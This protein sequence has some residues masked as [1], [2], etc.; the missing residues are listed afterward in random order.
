MKIFHCD[1]CDHLVFFENTHCVNCGHVLAF[2]PDLFEIGSLEA[3][4]AP[5][6]A[7]PSVA[8]SAPAGPSSQEPVRGQDWRGGRQRPRTETGSRR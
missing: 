4:P 3:A 8:A 2:L 7:A 6:A 1:H 5:T